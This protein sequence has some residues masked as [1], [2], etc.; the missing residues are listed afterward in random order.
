MAKRKSKSGNN[1]INA[2]LYIL[3]G[4]LFCVFRGGVI[5]WAMTAI[6]VV[7]IVTGILTILRG[8][9]VEGVISM[10]VGALVIM[11]GWLF[12][13]LVLLIFGVI[14]AAK[15]I[16][17]L[18]KA[19]PRGNINAVISAAVTTVVGLMLVV[20]KWALLDWLFIVIGVVLVIDGVLL[21]LGKK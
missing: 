1:L 4:I 14:I 5:D 20:S 7:W 9:I 8:G 2:I 13:D 10:A 21:L 11:G 16:I 6:G 12:V 17:E 15:G 18:V 19:L 3:V